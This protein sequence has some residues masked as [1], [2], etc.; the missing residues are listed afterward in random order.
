MRLIT[1]L[2]QEGIFFV[3]RLPLSLGS[4]SWGSL[5]ENCWEVKQNSVLFGPLSANTKLNFLFCPGTRFLIRQIAL[6][7]TGRDTQWSRH[8]KQSGSLS[9]GGLSETSG[10]RYFSKISPG[11]IYVWMKFRH[12]YLQ[13]FWNLVPIIL[14]YLLFSL[15]FSYFSAFSDKNLKEF[16]CFRDSKLRKKLDKFPIFHRVLGKIS[17]YWVWGSGMLE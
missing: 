16:I 12:N 4:V 8:Q 17:L 9:I 10:S 6:I 14:N 2:T 1:V 15:V 13:V 5:S 3:R 11:L 7:R